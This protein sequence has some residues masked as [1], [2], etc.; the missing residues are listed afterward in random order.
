M[1]KL[2]EAK[3]RYDSIYTLTYTHTHT[4]GMRMRKARSKNDS[5][6]TVVFTFV[7]GNPLRFFLFFFL[8][9]LSLSFSLSSLL[10]SVY[11]FV[12]LFVD[13]MLCNIMYIYRRYVSVQCTYIIWYSQ[14][15]MCEF[16]EHIL[17]RIYI[18][19]LLISFPTKWIEAFK[20]KRAKTNE[21]PTERTNER[22]RVRVDGNFNRDVESKFAE[23]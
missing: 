2:T 21:L 7:R 16:Y 8:F 4:K 11:W 14:W 15:N 23:I 17:N 3:R 18:D 5:C 22:V 13:R 9:S 19:G 12:Y 1:H 10:F 6:W 20:Q